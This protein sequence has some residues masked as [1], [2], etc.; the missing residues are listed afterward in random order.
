MT[1]VKVVFQGGGAKIVT[2]MAAASVLQDL[3][4]D[5]EIKIERAVG[6]S[7]GAIAACMLASRHPWDN[8][9]LRS[10]QAGAKV[11]A[12]VEKLPG[13]CKAVLRAYM[14]WPIFPEQA[15]R[16]FCRAVFSGVEVP[17]KSKPAENERLQ[18][19]GQL[20]IATSLVTASVRHTEK[21]VYHSGSHAEKPLEDAI[22]D[23]CAIPFV[24]RTF[25]DRDFLV[26]GGVC[27]NLPDGEVLGEKHGAFV[28]G[29]GFGPEESADP[30]NAF[31]YAKALVA[32]AMTSAVRDSM[33]RIRGTMGAVCE[34]PQTFGTFDFKAALEQ[35]LTE[36]IYADVRACVR[37][38]VLNALRSFREQV[39]TTEDETTLRR[40]ILVVHRQQTARFPYLVARSAML[41]TANSV[42]LATDPLRNEDDDITHIVEYRPKNADMTCLRLGLS[43]ASP[44]PLSG[45]SDYRVETMDGKPLGATQVLASDEYRSGNASFPRFYALFFLQQP[46]SEPV[47]IIQ[48]TRQKNAM[49]C[50]VEESGRDWLR[51]HNPS[52]QDVTSVDF[53]LFYPDHIGTIATLDLAESVGLLPESQRPLDIQ[54]MKER[55]ATGRPMSESEIDQYARPLAPSSCAMV[56]WRAD[57][58]KPAHYCGVMFQR[59]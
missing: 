28:L 58:V 18:R 54:V 14:G 25:K 38:Q 1:P 27:G 16:D 59:R 24:F 4:S 39:R 35:G 41:V 8:Y 23:S 53:V 10:K 34:L 44:P 2:L 26:D 31:D 9:R 40:K 47:R 15:L 11:I 50:L 12:S 33:A 49:G 22:C 52:E 7:A 3:E 36:K 29:F 21:R 13:T 5:G 57:K 19:L 56:G 20:P 51:S 30:S 48:R 32:T 42:R 45:E 43:A 55:W 46:V 6:V 17:N 37:P